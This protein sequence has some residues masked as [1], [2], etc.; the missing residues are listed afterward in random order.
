MLRI[1]FIFYG[2][3]PL[4]GTIIWLVWN[5]WQKQQIL[6][7]YWTVKVIEN[8]NTAIIYSQRTNLWSECVLFQI[9]VVL[10][11][12]HNKL[13]KITLGPCNATRESYL[14]FA[15]CLQSPN[16]VCKGTKHQSQCSRKCVYYETGSTSTHV[17]FFPKETNNKNEEYEEF[18]V[19]KLQQKVENIAKS[20]KIKY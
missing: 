3:A 1:S 17:K 9:C 7:T 13:R 15:E 4:Q 18:K 20:Y 2:A 6:E 12:P 5:E 19:A 10:S 14:R 8:G 11:H 16:L